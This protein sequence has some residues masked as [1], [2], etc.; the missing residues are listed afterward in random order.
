[1]NYADLYSRA[2]LRVGKGLSVPEAVSSCA[3]EEYPHAYRDVLDT[4]MDILERLKER[5]GWGSLRALREL[6]GN[7]R[8]VEEIRERPRNASPGGSVRGSG[9]EVFAD[10]PRIFSLAQRK[11][12]AGFSLEDCVDMAV[13]ELYPH[14]FRRTREAALLYLR[15]AAHRLNT[16]ELRALRELAEDPGLF[17]TL[18]GED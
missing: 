3:R 2:L 6:A 13:R 11:R 5:R 18:F 15:R 10:F 9:T 8:A 14:T 4:A 16:H 17:R 12:K 1:M 7:P